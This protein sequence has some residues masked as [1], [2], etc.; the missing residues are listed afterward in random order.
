LKT[1]TE[2]GVGVRRLERFIMKQKS[3]ESIEAA[4]KLLDEAA[5]QKKDEV[6]AAMSDRY[7]NL[8][9]LIIENEGSLMKSLATAKQHAIDATTHVKE[10]G[11]DKAREI[12]HDVDDGIH[13]NP[14][15]YI[16]GSSLVSVLVGFILGR[17]RK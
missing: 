17:S 11:V 6:V 15:P 13:E 7:T 10:A 2:K 4:L 1:F 3:S 9:N 16:A 14:W 5:K 12:A 8:R